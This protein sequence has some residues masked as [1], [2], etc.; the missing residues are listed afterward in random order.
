MTDLRQLEVS[1]LLTDSFGVAKAKLFDRHTAWTNLS[2]LLAGRFSLLP[3][4]Q[5]I[6]RQGDLD[7]LLCCVE[8]ELIAKQANAPANAGLDFTYHYLRMFSENWI[9]GFYEILRAFRQR[10]RER[11]ISSDSVSALPS[12]VRLLSD[13]ELLRMPLAKYEIAKD[14]KMAAPMDFIAIPQN[15]DA[16][17]N[18]TYSKNDPERSHFMPTGMSG[19][20]SMTWLAIDHNVPR[21]YWI[22]R[23]DLA[24]R[25]LALQNE[26][27]PAGI[28]EAQRAATKNS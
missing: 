9:M 17:D 10:D 5:S 19:R 7:L 1:P 26:V 14:A 4:M 11:G 18:R 25:L 24:D 13:F 15:G 21:E 6:Q 8:N 16:T 3:A 12:F 23:R 27:V 2:A 20:G 22:E 28:L